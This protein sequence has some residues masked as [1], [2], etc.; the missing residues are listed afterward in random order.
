MNKPRVR[1]LD[2]CGLDPCEPVALVQ[3]ALDQ[4]APSE[5]LC[6]LTEHEPFDLYRRLS[7][8][9]YA[10]CTRVLGAA[11]Y[12]VTIWPCG[13]RT[14]N[15]DRAPAIRWQARAASGR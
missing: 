1:H 9:A 4:L 14:P 12:E 7:N 2:V 3:D 8:Q 10:Y 6:L 13:T 15:P 5:Q 11:L